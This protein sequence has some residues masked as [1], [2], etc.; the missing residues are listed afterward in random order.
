MRTNK[1]LIVS[2]FLTLFFNIAM[3][4]KEETKLEGQQPEIGITKK[5]IRYPFGYGQHYCVLK[6][7][8]RRLKKPNRNSDYEPH[9][10]KSLKQIYNQLTKQ[11]EFLEDSVAKMRYDYFFKIS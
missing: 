6:I 11:R 3:G 5:S 10:I 1:I 8:S 4:G 9:F 7:C 2:A